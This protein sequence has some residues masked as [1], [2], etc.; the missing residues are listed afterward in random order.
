MFLILFLLSA[1]M[2]AGGFYF[3]LLSLLKMIPFAL[4]VPIL[5]VTILLFMLCLNYRYKLNKLFHQ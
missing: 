2:L 1:F 4:S 5:F 3:F